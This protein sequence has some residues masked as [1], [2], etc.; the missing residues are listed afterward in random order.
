[1][2]YL[3]LEDLIVEDPYVNNQYLCNNGLIYGIK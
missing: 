2:G 1:M 3:L